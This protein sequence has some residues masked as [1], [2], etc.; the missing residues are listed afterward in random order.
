MPFGVASALSIIGIIT[1]GDNTSPQQQAALRN[2]LANM[3]PQ[4]LGNPGVP[5]LDPGTQQAAAEAPPPS[6]VVVLDLD[7]AGEIRE[8]AVIG[9]AIDL[10][11]P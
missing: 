2:A 7:D 9:R 1:Q 5:Y 11:N 8:P 3:I 10:E 6:R 4:M